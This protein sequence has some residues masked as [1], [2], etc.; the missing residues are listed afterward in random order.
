MRDRFTIAAPMVR[1]IIGMATEAGVDVSDMLSAHGF[2]AARLQEPDARVPHDLTIHL[3]EELPRRAKDDAFGLHLA[4]RLQRG[5]DDVTDQVMRHAATLGDA[6]R[7]FMRYQRLLHDAAPFEMEVGDSSVRLVH[8]WTRRGR[9]ALP[10][11]LSEF[12]IAALLVRGRICLKE[13]WTP[14]EV[15]FPHPAPA[16]TREHQKLFRAPIHFEQSLSEL[17]FHRRILDRPSP[18]ADPALSTVLHRY[19]ESLLGQLPEQ[20]DFLDMVRRPILQGLSGGV[21]A[22]ERVARQ[23]GL[24]KRSFFRRLQ[25]HATS[26]QQIVDEIRRDLTL[27]H[28]REGRLSLS[29]IAFL[30]G[31]AEVSTFHRAFRRWSGQSPAEYR[32]SLVEQP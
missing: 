28:L 24:S 6:Y 30:V 31:Y 16:S 27:H 12:V 10:R 11:H 14:L 20:G 3:W 25:E 18:T 13:E 23:L 26:Y 17:I 7:L 5:V 29:E 32:R 2:D 8:A 1:L 22:A 15:R 21:P 4:R 19:A 9:H